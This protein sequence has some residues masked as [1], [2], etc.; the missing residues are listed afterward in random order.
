MDATYLIPSTDVKVESLPKVGRRLRKP[1]H[2]FQLRYRPFQIQPF[3]IAPVLPGETMKNLLMQAKTVTDPLANG[4]IGWHNEY[5]F[6]YVKLRDLADRAT[7]EQMLIA[8]SAPPAAT[9]A[10]VPAFYNGEG[11]NWVRKCLDRV[12]ETYFRSE[13]EVAAAFNPL[14]DTMPL[15]SVTSMPGWMENLVADSDAPVSDGVPLP[16]DYWPEIPAQYVGTPFEAAYSQ[17]K[18]MQS[19]Q[20]TPPSF[21]DWLKTFGIRPP[22][23]TREEKHIPELIRYVRDWAMP[24]DSAGGDGIS[25]RVTWT[26]AERA[27]KDRFFSEPGFIFGVTTCRA[28]MYAQAQV[29]NMASFLNDAYSW[30]PALLRPD[31]FTSLKKFAFGGAGP[32]SNQTEDYWVDLADF[33]V[34]GDQ[35]FNFGWDT[36]ANYLTE[37]SEGGSGIDVKKTYPNEYSIDLLFA[38]SATAKLIKCE[39][40]VDLNILSALQDTTPA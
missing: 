15:A 32:L 7:I 12:V 36:T 29:G 24:R 16:G 11:V 30:L 5:Y 20:I 33:F 38:D 25:P 17:W 6:F 40:R 8:N 34:G 22:V 37:P 1:T 21:E 9:A 4:L 35:F 19:L 39:G 31:P 2:S 18:E 13:E 10:D 26:T 27:D 23:A 14:L 3:L 28:K